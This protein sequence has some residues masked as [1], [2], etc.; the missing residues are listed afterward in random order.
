MTQMTQSGD[1][2][3]SDFYRK[4]F[5]CSPNPVL[6]FGL[7]SRL[8]LSANPAIHA[9]LNDPAPVIG[10]PVQALLGE[11]M[12][13]TLR[14]TLE[15]ILQAYRAGGM[16]G[17]RRVR[18]L[19]RIIELKLSW[20][21]EEFFGQAA[22]ILT[23]HDV[24]ERER[25]RG[26]LERYQAQLESLVEERTTALRNAMR[27]AEAANH[28]KGIFLANMSHELRTP[29]NAIL[30]FSRLLQRDPVMP[31]EHQQKLATIQ[32]AGEHLLALINDVLQLSRS[33]DEATLQ[34]PSPFSLAGLL[35]D[36]E[37]EMRPRAEAR[38]LRF[39]L[40]PAPPGEVLGHPEGL[41]RILIGLLGNA[42]KYTDAGEVSL[43]LSRRNDQVSFAIRDTGPGI[44]PA[45]RA[46]IFQPF[47]QTSIGRARGEGTGLGL[48]LGREYA[49]LMGGELSLSEA[50][51]TAGCC[52]VLE[53]PLPIHDAA[54][55]QQAVS[56]FAD[57]QA[58]PHILVVDDQPDNRWLASQLL[59]TLG[60]TVRTAENGEEAVTA[61]RAAAP[62]MIWMDV[63]MPVMDGPSATRAIRALPGGE[64]VRIV[65]MTA[66]T[67]QQEKDDILA[68]GCDAIIGKP[69]D[70]AEI[71][72][73]LQQLLGVRFTYEAVPGQAAL[74]HS[75]ADAGGPPALPEAARAALRDAAT[76]LDV[77]AC[78]QIA[79]E[80]NAAHPSA[81][82]YLLAQVEQFRFDLLQGWAEG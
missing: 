2:G 14:D 6:I 11:A 8:I 40:S 46:Q 65:A 81:A 54:P 26:E 22:C 71:L 57:V 13:A 34:A 31:A 42:I 55:A 58:A 25:F 7:E 29:L 50:A 12:S 62:D 28:A 45:E 48:Y 5:Q 20:P 52:F 21:P 53:V 72:R 59:E 32:R 15:A 39:T 73:V 82:A 49:R 23:L 60:A 67:L 64:Q 51:Q 47:A 79:E 33:D 24:S 80:L 69:L 61:F 68:A 76:R 44:P 16:P 3:D 4:L 66:S 18:W 56:G 70:E 38:Q 9:L 37:Q 17:P 43:Q 35:Q 41:R 78:R 1:A 36:I 30:G 19:E 10:K 27:E 75:P 74:G 63:R 77:E